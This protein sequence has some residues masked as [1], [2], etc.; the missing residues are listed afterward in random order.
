MKKTEIHGLLYILGGATLWGFSS[1]VAKALFHVGLS[2]FQLVSIRLP[3]AAVILLVVLLLYD[4]KRLVVASKDIPYFILFGTLGVVGN[5][6]TFY[7]TIS[8]IQVGPAVLIQY[9]A[10]IWITLFAVFFQQERFSRATLTAM[11]FAL[12]GCYFAVGGYRAD[13]LRLNRVGILSG[14]ISSFFVAFYAL[15]GEKGLKRY[16]T[17]TLI[18]YGFALGGLT[19]WIL[20]PPVGIFKVS[21]PPKIWAAFLYIAIFAT[22]IPFGLYFKGID[23]LRATR[24]SILG[25]WEPVMSCITAYVILGEVLE[26]LQI[27]GGVAVIAAVIVLQ[28]SK[29]KQSIPAPFE[30]RNS[31]S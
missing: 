12:L 10:V 14:V 20:S 25:T 29:E 19:C 3:L 30:I 24:A 7:F 13:L 21:Y 6:L 15:Y 23:R 1:T 4:R 5:Q 31:V 18:F 2:P 26:P 27:L 11:A 22:L 28:V 16:D 17:W 9:I 8:K